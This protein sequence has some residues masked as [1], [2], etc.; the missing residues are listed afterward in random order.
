MR[1][2]VSHASSDHPLVDALG[3]LIGGAFVEHVDF[4]SSS[5]SVES[6]GIPAGSS[7]LTWIYSQVSQSQVA[8]VVLTP[9][10]NSR[11]W[12]M[13]EAGAVSGM[14]LAQGSPTPV[15]PL[16]FGLEP[17]EVPSP[18]RD[19]QTKSGLT[20][21]G[22]KDVLESIRRIGNLT[23]RSPPEVEALSTAYLDTVAECRIPGMHDL[24]VSC[25]MSSLNDKE[26]EQVGAT[27]DSLVEKIKAAGH[28]V[29]CARCRVGAGQKLDPEKVA[30]EEDFAA[31]KASRN[32]VMVYPK[33]V[34][35]SCLLE[36]GYALVSGI[37]STYFV[38]RDDD[39]PYMLKGAI[40]SFANV[41]RVR[42]K[43][44]S[45]IVDYFVRYPKRIIR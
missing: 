9:L 11:A 43:D 7:W 45:E 3:D 25:P 41:E 16:L 28:S 8:I 21:A 26:Y 36:A 22:I 30:A 2:F 39:L 5:S 6:G 12:L 27:I 42:F 23:Y 14:G 29:Y 15:I 33:R 18:L 17:D 24:F 13:W 10:S 34:V 31:L 44:E 19:K 35:S 38:R 1:V 32:F 20:L 4:S 40:E 37:R